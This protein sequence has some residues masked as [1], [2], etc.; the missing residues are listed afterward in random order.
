[1]LLQG[2]APHRAVARNYQQLGD[3]GLDRIKPYWFT[4]VL[5]AHYSDWVSHPPRK[6]ARREYDPHWKLKLDRVDQFGRVSLQVREMLLEHK[7]RALAFV[8][9]GQAGQGMQEFHDRLEVD[10]PH[11][12]GE[13]AV[14]AYRP[15]WP[16]YADDVGAAIARE[17]PSEVTKRSCGKRSRWTAWTGSV[18]A[19]GGT[20]A[21]AASWWC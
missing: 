21:W 13:A 16:D 1:M 12:V 20:R 8:W 4:P 5:Y 3:I 7:P 18:P 14:V 10:L 15:R 17:S 11:H 9:Y 6:L 19:C 2:T